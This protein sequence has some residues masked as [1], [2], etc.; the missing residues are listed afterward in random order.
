MD[1]DFGNGQREQAPCRVVKKWVEYGLPAEVVA[2]VEAAQRLSVQLRIIDVRW[3]TRAGRRCRKLVVSYARGSGAPQTA[4]DH[5]VLFSVQHGKRGGLG[6]H[7]RGH[8]RRQ[9]QLRERVRAEARRQ[10]Q[11]EEL[12]APERLVVLVREAHAHEARDG[13]GLTILAWDPVMCRVSSTR[14]E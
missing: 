10:A 7:N 4:P 2:A 3:A 12:C 1:V 5:V 13:L 14:V 11:H 6:R 8:F 9:Q